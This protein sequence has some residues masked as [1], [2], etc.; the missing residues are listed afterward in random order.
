MTA[1]L[2]AREHLTSFAGEVGS[3]PSVSLAFVCKYCLGPA[4]G[5]P[6]CC[7]CS[8]LAAAAPHELAARIVPMTTVVNPSLWYRRLVGYK[9]GVEEH[10]TALAALTAAYLAAHET[11]L[12]HLLGGPIARIVVV[13]STR[14]ERSEDHPLARV[15]RRTKLFRDRFVNGLTYVTG[16]TI[17]R[18]EYKPSIY[19]VDAAA[20]RGQ[21][22]LLIEDLW[23][24]GAKAV[25]AAG[26]VLD[27]G[28]ASVVIT[29]IAREIRPSTSFCPDEYVQASNVAFDVDAWPR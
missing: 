25:S 3:V 4:I 18:Q 21:R 9:N 28:A 23:V 15:V 22:V 17:A 20:L 2:S 6:R 24:S 16:A 5:Y 11:D 10:H 1:L 26:A 12:A 14:R 7:G 27:A 13:P 8:R 19:S 29:P